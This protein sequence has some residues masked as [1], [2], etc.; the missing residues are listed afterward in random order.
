MKK[1]ISANCGSC[2]QCCHFHIYIGE[3]MS[4]ED[5]QKEFFFTR[6]QCETF[7]EKKKT[8]YKIGKS[9]RFMHKGLC[10]IHD[11]P[12]QYPLSC[13]IFPAVLVTDKKNKTH[14]ALDKNCPDFEKIKVSFK[15][16]DF[17]ANFLQIL[18]YYDQENRLDILS[19]EDLVTCG[20]E[21]EL[22]MEDIF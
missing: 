2:R 15:N 12:E 10:T 22:I 6:E 1:T 11:N 3:T 18:E 19:Y 9:C 20:Y 4:L 5:L 21:L 16:D 17:M 7:F 14:V 8:R 13:A